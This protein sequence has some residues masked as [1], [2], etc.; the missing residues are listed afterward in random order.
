MEDSKDNLQSHI[1][2]LMKSRDEYRTLHEKLMQANQFFEEREQRDR[3][4]INDLSLETESLR[5]Q[6]EDARAAL[7]SQHHMSATFEK[8]VQSLLRVASV[9]E[10]REREM[11]KNVLERE[12]DMQQMLQDREREL[13]KCKQ[14]HE[15]ELLKCKQDHERDVKSSAQQSAA[16]SFTAK[17]LERDN[18]ALRLELENFR[19][20]VA[21]LMIKLDQSESSR[22]E[23]EY[24]IAEEKKDADATKRDC[25]AL[26]AE[27]AA[28]DEQRIVSA[29]R[30]VLLEGS[31]ASLMTQLG[32]LK[33]TN[34]REVIARDIAEK[35][36]KDLLIL[37]QEKQ[38]EV[39]RFRKLYELDHAELESCK[40]R[41][42]D[43]ERQLNDSTRE[44]GEFH[45]ML[46]LEVGGLV[47]AE[48]VLL[49][50]QED[51]DVTTSV[52]RSSPF[53]NGENRD[54][55]DKRTPLKAPSTI[56]RVSYDS[57]GSIT[58]MTPETFSR[59]TALTADFGYD[60]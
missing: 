7:A 42:L 32:A 17:S 46:M 56:K 16:D 37:M 48:E 20:E 15:R 19:S 43:T 35:K 50:A 53:P 30:I 44:I 21:R 14:D 54:S 39:V 23:L 5:K 2:L 9:L 6:L 18:A 28:L 27:L 10:D 3:R 1:S 8:D 45:S 34:R 26:S 31:K 40:L 51:R 60:K 11:Q 58:Q 22:K 29:E 33:Q 25:V 47:A 52:L 59:E 57:R 55:L 4:K 12:R 36:N 41:L 38:E 13:Q 49:F 24:L